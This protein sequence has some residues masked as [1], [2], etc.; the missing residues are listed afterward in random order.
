MVIQAPTLNT[1]PFGGNSL[2]SSFTIANGPDIQIQITVNF[3]ITYPGISL[4]TNT[5]TFE[6]GQESASFVI[7]SSSDNAVTGGTK[8][9]KGTLVLSLTGIN[10][11]IYELSTS[12]L[13]FNIGDTD[14]SNPEI[15]VFEA[16]SVTQHTATITVTTNE[17]VMLYYMY[18]LAGT[19]IP[20]LA[21]VQA[22]G[23]AP[24]KTTKSIYGSYQINSNLTA[25][26]ELSNLVAETPYVLYMYFVDCG[27]NVVFNSTNFTTLG[28][29]RNFANIVYLIYL[30]RYNGVDFS[31][32]FLQYDIS[33]AE[34]QI[35]INAVSF[36]LSLF[37]GK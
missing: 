27:A 11:G 24:Y 21:E 3:L 18:A 17:V 6:A 35:I 23:P 26:F 10:A 1:I 7:Y 2:P 36:T 14:L 32:R 19:D 33:E 9:Q 20:T 15:Y 13:D 25:T 8:V 16:T 29:K 34:M 28:N 30:D 22:L 5:I 12:T 4:S 37:P 31:M